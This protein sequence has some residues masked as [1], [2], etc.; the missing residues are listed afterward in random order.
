MKECNIVGIDLAKNV[1]HICEMTKH[2][3][4]IRRRKCSRSKLFNVVVKDFKGIIAMEAC[5]GA[6]YWSRR[7][8]A[9]GY[10]T[11]MIAGQ[12]VK[13]FVKSNKNDEID[14]EAICEASSRP[15]MR[16]VATR[17]EE[18]QDIQ[19]LHRIRERLVGQ[20]TGLSNE[21]R[22][23]LL[24]Y[25]ITIPQGISN[26][27]K[28]LPTL[29]EEHGCEHSEL[30]LTTFRDL[31]EEFCALDERILRHEKRLHLIAHTNESCKRL[32]AI[33]GIGIITATAIF[34]AVGNARAFKNGRQFA[35]WIGLT[36]KEYSTG[37]KTK[38]G[39]ISKR[40]D[41]YLR[42]LLIQG[43]R[44]FAIAAQKKKNH[45]DP[46]KRQTDDTAKWLFDVAKRTGSNKA[47]VAMANKTA[48]RIWIVLAKKEDFKQP[49]ELLEMA[50]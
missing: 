30:W 43:A 33:P 31:Y 38:L 8:Q 36:P 9:A 11:R 44:S 15:Q 39:G 37:G 32:L 10:E 14:A 24:E 45:K 48:R 13:P 22:G 49:E 42:K 18:Q 2:G 7:F 40:G 46:L 16:F 3:R 21:I 50:A 5:G 25:G 23:L 35:A 19:S 27:R 12:F 26:V 4:V 6:H 17:S 41:N 47:I 28:K 29:L 34:A 20:R 1:F